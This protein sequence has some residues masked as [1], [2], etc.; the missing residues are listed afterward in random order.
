M[1]IWSVSFGRWKLRF[2]NV[3]MKTINISFKPILMIFC[4]CVI[5]FVRRV[6]SEPVLN[7]SRFANENSC[8]FWNASFS[9]VQENLTNI[10]VVKSFVREETEKERFGEANRDLRDSSLDA[11]KIVIMTMPIHIIKPRNQL[12]HARLSGACRTND[13]NRLPRICSKT[14]MVQDIILIVLIIASFLCL[15]LHLCL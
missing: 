14:D 15:S 8:T 5:S 9:S 11:F 13:A 10:R 2:R 1:D 12:Y 3:K 4:S 7:L 6:T